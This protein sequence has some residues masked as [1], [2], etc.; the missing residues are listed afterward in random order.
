MGERA[1]FG[2]IEDFG[3][4]SAELVDSLAAGSAGLAGGFVEIDD[5]D[6]ADADGG[7]MKADGSRDGVLLGAGSESVRGVFHIAPGDDVSVFEKDR[8]SYTEV[9]VGGVGVLSGGGGSL[10][11]VFELPRCELAGEGI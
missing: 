9:A 3:G 6:S 1:V 8:G 10:A 4:W 7:A 11:K 5:Y 2:G